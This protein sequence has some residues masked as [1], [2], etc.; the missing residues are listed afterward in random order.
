[1]KTDKTDQGEMTVPGDAEAKADV[2]ALEFDAPV[3]SK[4]GR[5]IADGDFSLIRDVRVR[6]DVTVGA[7]NLTVKE[8]FD[9]RESHVVSL[10]RTTD[11]PVDVLLDGKLVARGTLVAVGDSFGVQILEIANHT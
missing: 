2:E 7:C 10:D 6:L 4:E 3:A 11:Q 9:L 1:M 8:L 5:Q